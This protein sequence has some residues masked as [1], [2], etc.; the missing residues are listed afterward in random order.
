MRWRTGA[1]GDEQIGRSGVELVRKL[2]RNIG[3]RIGAGL[4][5]A[6]L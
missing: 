2:A 6:L 3:V 4:V 1:R 5:Q